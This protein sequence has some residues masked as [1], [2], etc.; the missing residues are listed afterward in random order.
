M[1]WAS[2][3]VQGFTPAIGGIEMFQPVVQRLR[4]ELRNLRF[5]L[6]GGVFDSLI[7]T[8]RTAAAAAHADSGQAL[9]AICK[10]TVDA[11]G[12]DRASIFI[13]DRGKFR[14]RANFGNPPDVAAVFMR[15]STRLDDPLIVAAMS[16][17]GRI[18]V[19]DVDA[20]DI[21]NRATAR[22]AR[23]RAIAIALMY[24]SS[25]R[26]PIGFMT[27]EFNERR[28]RITPFF[29]RLL[30]SSA[31][32]VEVVIANERAALA[33][34][35]LEARVRELENVESIAR[36]CGGIA[37]DVNNAL[38]V[39]VGNAEL[40]ERSMPREQE[41][42]DA[43]RQ[44][45]VAV[46]HATTLT[47]NLLAF[48]HLAM[49]RA[50]V[51]DVNDAIRRLEPLLSS[52]VS[53][54]LVVVYSLEARCA[55]VDIDP[56]QLEQVLINLVSNAADALGDAGTIDIG[57]AN[58]GGWVR[59]W[60]H[61]DGPGF[62]PGEFVRAVEPFYSTKDA[63]GHSGIGLA[64]VTAI[65][66]SAKGRIEHVAAGSGARIEI[67][68]PRSESTPTL[69]REDPT[70]ALPDFD[71][72]SLRVMVVDDHPNVLAVAA[73]AMRRRG[74]N[75]RTAGGGV[76]ALQLLEVD[77]DVDL[78]ITDIMM[79]GMDGGELARRVRA[80]SPFVRVVYMSGF[81]EPDL[82]DETL[83]DDQATLIFKPFTADQLLM[84]A[85]QTIAG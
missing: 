77:R 2:G 7:A 58:E 13:V 49:G 4:N 72:S 46:S 80:M 19:N 57:T 38:T 23:I 45:T 73:N 30:E 25:G 81:A 56:G 18:V 60:I 62:A 61:D 67:R 14:A 68:L 32:I 44:L 43:Y 52:Y 12:C 51:I 53:P 39:I 34:A 9:T 42:L 21:V 85:Y 28:G 37:H 74:C 54:N 48:G 83:A 24:E 59:I 50:E 78:L 5:V 27:L 40:M 69:E 17:G 41:H 66:R 26:D 75:V 64:T 29:S 11:V 65:V 36:M 71:W 79:P 82:L 16:R 8:L 76:E 15:H 33:R 31:R 47:R 1:M 84:R 10:A 63:G 6:T 3:T 55:F 20:S 22:R 35:A 70:G